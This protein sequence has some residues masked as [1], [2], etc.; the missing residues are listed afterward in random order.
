[1]LMGSLLPPP[2]R[3]FLHPPLPPAP[4][5]ILLFLASCLFLFFFLPFFFPLRSFTD[6]HLLS[7]RGRSA[8]PPLSRRAPSHPSA[9]VY[10]FTPP[11][12]SAAL[13]LSLCR[14]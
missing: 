6:Q 7:L 5:L 1:M 13:C 11:P 2:K 10:I 4:H 14:A 12:S 8:P 9:P 3:L